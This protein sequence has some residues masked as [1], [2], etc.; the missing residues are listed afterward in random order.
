[1]KKPIYTRKGD[2]GMTGLFSGERIEKTNSRVEAY[3]TIDELNTF[4][5]VARSFASETIQEIILE[6]QQKLFYIMSELATTN[7]EKVIRSTTAEDVKGLERVMDRLSEEMPPSKH[8]VI[9][10][11][12][13][14]AAFLHTARTICRR[15]ERQLIRFSINNEVNSDLLKY[16]NRLSDFIFVLARY[17][18]IVDG[19][20]DTIIS[21]DG[22]RL[23]K[24]QTKI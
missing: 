8:F 1:M 12:T 22:I 5:G 24:K 7:K 15:A 10:G 9:P 16:I 14:A 23:Q 6:V 11:G 13:K 2:K 3:G 17:A 18:N 19:E 21:R 20:G 4:L